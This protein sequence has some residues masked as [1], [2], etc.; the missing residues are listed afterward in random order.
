M[1]YCWLSDV[2]TSPI[3]SDSTKVLAA[4]IYP[5]LLSTPFPSTVTVDTDC[6]HR[7]ADKVIAPN[8]VQRR[9]G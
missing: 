2:L 7:L 3:I 1:W 9:A 6:V 5:A 4:Q 8:R